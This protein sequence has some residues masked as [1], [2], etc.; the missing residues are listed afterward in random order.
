MV[1]SDGARLLWPANRSP[2]SWSAYTV[3]ARAGCSHVWTQ[4]SNETLDASKSIN[5]L[6]KYAQRRFCMH[7]LCLTTS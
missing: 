3:G 5:M 4:K 1:G 2:W 7:S 6:K